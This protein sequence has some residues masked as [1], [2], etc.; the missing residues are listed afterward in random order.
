MPF[1]FSLQAVLGFRYSLERREYLALQALLSKRT[2]L[3]RE[4]E[5]LTSARLRLVSDLRDT[6]QSDGISGAEL[7]VVAA[8]TKSFSSA[9]DRFEFQLQ[10]VQ[11]EILLQRERYRHQRQ[12]RETLESV[13]DRQFREY[14]SLEQRREQAML[15]EL[16][17][18]R[19]NLTRQ[20]LPI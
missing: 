16:H 12:Q 18:I 1:H 2:D 19:R 11:H 20:H 17:L 13:R 9:T 10:K 6:F 15:D 3:L 8:K 14:Q 7:E 4:I 5:N